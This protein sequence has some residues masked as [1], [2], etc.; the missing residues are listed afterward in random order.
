MSLTQRA[1]SFISEEEY[2][3]TERESETKHEYFQGEI[4]AMAGASKAHNLI[5]T[6]VIREISTQLK[7]TPC[8]V[9]PSDLRVKI[10]DTGLYTYPDVTVVCGEEKFSDDRSDTLLNPKIIIEVLSDSTERYDRGT[11]FEHYRKLESLKEYVMI[12]QNR[13]KIEKFFKNETGF[14]VLTESDEDNPVIIL[15][16]VNCTLELSELYDKVE[17]IYGSP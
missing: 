14:W 7:K 13:P 5:V 17:N 11:K 15:E 10:T 1:V 6:N 8:R 3:E 2:L 12:S 4:F 9:Y 16:S